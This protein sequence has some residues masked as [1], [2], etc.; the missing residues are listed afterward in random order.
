MAYLGEALGVDRHESPKDRI[1]DLIGG[2]PRLVDAVMAALR[3]AVSRDDVPEVGQTV[4]WSLESEHSWLAFP[5][6]ASLDLLDKE[7][8]ARLDALQKAQKR[9][10]LA[11]YYCV[12][13]GAE[14]PRW[15]DRWLRH[16]PRPGSRH[17][18][19]MRGGSGFAP[20][21]SSRLA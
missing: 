16:D 5:V 19:S 18:V 11:I 8:P 10:V 15:H 4:S 9:K 17:S 20:V 21:R 7:D 14:T 3:G 2:D 12:R 1:G 6:L 13:H